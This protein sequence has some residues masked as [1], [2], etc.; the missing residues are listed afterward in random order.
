MEDK[1]VAI[2]LL[3]S[4]FKSYENVVLNF[5]MSI[6]ELRTQDVVKVLT[7]EH[8]KLLGESIATVKTEDAAKV[9][10]AERKFSQCTYYNK[11]WH[12]MERCWTKQKDNDQG[13]RRGGH[14]RG[15]EP[16]IVQYWHNDKYDRVAFAISLKCELST[17][18]DML[19]M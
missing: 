9:F 3:H 8:I 14:I 2:C 19:E 16:S 5:K 4:L 10:G 13:D 17:G 7:N 11:S 18:N 6:A 15:R 12:T 1:D